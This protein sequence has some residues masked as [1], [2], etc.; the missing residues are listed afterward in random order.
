MEDGGNC[1]AAGG[2]SGGGFREGRNVPIDN[3]TASPLVPNPATNAGLPVTAQGYSITVGGG[4]S[5]TL[6]PSDAGSTGNS[7]TSSVFST[8]TSAGGG[9]G[10][11]ASGCAPV[12]QLTGG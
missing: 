12:M 4:G 3:F 9:Y 6:T 1:N 5:G 10:G 7:G 8:I 11:I 2:G